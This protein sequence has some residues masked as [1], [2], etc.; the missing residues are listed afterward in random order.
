MSVKNPKKCP[1]NRPLD[2]TFLFEYSV[3]RFK[4]QTVGLADFRW[5]G[6]IC[7]RFTLYGRTFRESHLRELATAG[8]WESASH[9]TLPIYGL[10]I[11]PDPAVIDHLGPGEKKWCLSA[12]KF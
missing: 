8:L 4:S 3:G 12:T 7:F 5:P 9:R 6:G 10:L 2:R 1:I 11:L